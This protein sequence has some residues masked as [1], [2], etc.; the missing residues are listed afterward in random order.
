MTKGL[1]S[2]T[3][4]ILNSLTERESKVIRM[5]FGIGLNTDHTLEE[6]GKQFDVTRERIRQ[7]GWARCVRC[8]IPRAQKSC[9]AT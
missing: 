9:E 3:D 7:I 5:R 4:S 1:T 6:V 8:V 2:A